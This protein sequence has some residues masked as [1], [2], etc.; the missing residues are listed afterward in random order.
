M[1]LQSVSIESL[2]LCLISNFK[3]EILPFKTIEMDL[4]SVMLC[5]KRQR[6]T[7]TVCFPLY[8]EFKKS[9][10]WTNKTETDSQIW[11]GGGERAEIGEKA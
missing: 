6:K 5:E 7:N 2:S 8:A 10:K 3:N 1:L 4:E 9:N 11:R